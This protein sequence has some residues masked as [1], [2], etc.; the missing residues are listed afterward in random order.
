M[1][2]KTLK[3]DKVN[4][5]T[6][7][8][9]KNL[10]DSEVLSGQLAAN[11]IDV[12]HE[13]AKLDHNIVVVNTCGF[14]DKAKEES[15]NTILDQVELKRRGKLDKVYVTGCLSERYRG[16]LEA[17]MPEVD[18]WFGTLEL[19]LILKQFE[20]DYK[21]ELLGERML[22]TPK[23]Y[24]YLKIAE[25]CNR[26]CS[27]CAIP[28]MRGKHISRSIED[29]VAEAESLVQKGV[30]E[31][32]LI[33]QELTYYG[34][35]LYKE[36]ALPKLLDALADVKGIEWIRLHYAYPSKFPLE[37]LEVMQRRDNICKYLDMPLQHASNRMLKAMRRN[38]TREEMSEL[39][40]Q[41]KAAVPGI[42]LR[43]TLIAGFP[44][45]TEEDVEELK[46]FLQEHRFDR[47]GIFSYSHE[48]NTSAYDLVDDVP[49]DVKA[50]RAQ[51]IMEVQQEISYEK[52]QEKV[53]KIFKV[54]IDKKEAGRYLGRTEFDSVEVDNEV[55]IHSTKKLPIGEFVQV[56]ITKAY[57]Y[58]LEGEVVV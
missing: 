3:K 36:R 57:D 38:I 54:L 25:G 22:S 32:M 56:K 6:L 14:I 37:I 45:E 10:V 27:F 51:E 55:V 4:I 31:I 5:I 16:D 52:N 33:A 46:A 12:V 43:T 53:G 20:A 1:K 21:A 48:E 8:C 42:C 18:A 17:E 24:A 23:H 28:L 39:I 30:K 47:V 34:L 2:A 41:I 9:S 29:L 7:G 13:N 26:T 49:A 44:G 58:D 19:P 40:H 35:D 50:A 11:D 15:I